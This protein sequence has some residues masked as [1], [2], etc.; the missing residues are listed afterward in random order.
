MRERKI[1]TVCKILIKLGIKLKCL[2]LW[3]ESLI[4]RDREIERKRENQDQL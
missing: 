1:G 4:E 2:H 3:K